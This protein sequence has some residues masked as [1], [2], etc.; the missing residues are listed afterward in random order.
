MVSPVRFTPIIVA[1]V[2]AGSAAFATPC[3]NDLPVLMIVQDK[4]GSMSAVPDSTA[5]PTCPTKWTSAKSA[6]AT[7]TNNFQGAFRFGVEMYPGATSQFNCTTG[8][9]TNAVPSTPAQIQ[10]T[11]NASVPG[12]GTPT[13]V[14]LG[15]AKTY[16]Q[17][18][19]L[20]TPAYVLLFTDGLPNCNLSLD[21]NTCTA[22]TPGCANNACGL[23]AKDCLDDQG[24]VAAAQDLLAAGY[25][26]YVVGFGTA[27]T[28]GNNLTVLN[29]VAAAGGTGSAYSANDQAALDAALS[30]IGYNAATCCKD[31]CTQGTGMCDSNG[32]ATSC[33]MDAQLGCTVWTTQACAN[34]SYCDNGACVS[35][36][37]A[38]IAGATQCV[39]NSAQECIVNAHGCT[40]WKQVDSCLFGEVC[41]QGQCQSCAACTEGAT[42]CNGQN[43]DVCVQDLATGCTAW[44]TKPCTFGSACSGAASSCQVCNATC[45]AGA[46]RCSGKVPETC[47]ADAFGCTSWQAGTECA[48]FCSGGACGS[49]GTS[50]AI[51]DAQCNGSTVES[52]TTDDN[53]CS[54]WV[55]GQVCDVSAGEYCKGAGCKRCTSSCAPGALQCSATGIEECQVEATG[56][57]AWKTLETCGVD[58]GCI[59]GQCVEQC[60]NTCAPGGRKCSV[61]GEPLL[62]ELGPAG[63]TVWVA[64]APCGNAQVCAEGVCVT[65]CGDSDAWACNEDEECRA[66]DGHNVC[67]PIGLPPKVKAGCT[68]AAVDP[69]SILGIALLSLGALGLRR[70]RHGSAGRC[71]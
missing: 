67:A 35:C 26:V 6:I 39:G 44:Q 37:D 3:P 47:V 9:V 2:L 61:S 69:A 22:T 66:I 65:E 64:E 60:K 57:T 62:C 34:R 33:V 25:K 30:A 50:C 21:P 15:A 52:C 13:A 41:S 24:T 68:C 59:S 56:C 48:T 53:G 43:V 36:N 54:I 38:C 71:L 55:P 27:A 5:C 31:L 70:R 28:T 63:C 58:E 10:T 4:S 46:Q 12:G 42:Q 51:G 14:S 23:G 49:C 19:N 20:T 18:L 45:T 16:L 40:E 11:Y 29:S 17:S 7:L 8:S 32:N 1:V